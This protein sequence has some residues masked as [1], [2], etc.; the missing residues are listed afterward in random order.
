MIHVL[1][2][3]PSAIH[4]LLNDMLLD[5]EAKVRAKVRE[6]VDRQTIESISAPQ[7]GCAGR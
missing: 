7:G 3:M 4:R 5:V 1:V 2:A 6:K